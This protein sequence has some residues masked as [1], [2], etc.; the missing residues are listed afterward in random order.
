MRRC[1]APNNVCTSGGRLLRSFH[2]F[3]CDFPFELRQ[4]HEFRIVAPGPELFFGD[5]DGYATP[6]SHMYRHFCARL[7]SR[8]TRDRPIPLRPSWA[9]VRF[10]SASKKKSRE[11][12]SGNSS[13]IICGQLSANHRLGTPSLSTRK[14]SRKNVIGIACE[15]AGEIEP[16]YGR[17]TGSSS[18]TKPGSSGSP[19]TDAGWSSTCTGWP[20]R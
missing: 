19:L 14:S 7:R 8:R 16:A 11:I 18:S 9:S 6:V 10:F 15:D 17:H 2:R 5:G 1:R 20:G 3:H 12:S 4:V 13:S